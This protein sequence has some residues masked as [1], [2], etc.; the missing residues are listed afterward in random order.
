[1]PRECARGTIFRNDAHQFHIIKGLADRDIQMTGCAV[2][3]GLAAETPARVLLTN[4]RRFYGL[5][6]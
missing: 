2:A 6:I 4:A 1:L 5:A 3:A